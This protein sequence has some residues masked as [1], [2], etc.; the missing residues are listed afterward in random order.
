MNIQ[1]VYIDIDGVLGDYQGAVLAAF[2]DRYGRP[3]PGQGLSDYLKVGG[4]LIGTRIK[5][6]GAAF[7]AQMQLMPDAI[8]I[9]NV[10]LDRFPGDQLYLVS[11]YTD[12]LSCYI[13]K[14]SWVKLLFPAM[15]PRLRLVL[16]KAE[17]AGPGVLLI[18]D[19]DDVAERFQA[20]GGAAIVV[21]RPWNKDHG[22]A[23]PRMAGWLAK[24]LDGLGR[25][26]PATQTK[27][28][29]VGD[30]EAK[31]SDPAKK[32]ETIAEEF[33][34][35]VEVETEEILASL[36]KRPN[37]RLASEMEVLGGLSTLVQ[38]YTECLDHEDCDS[39]GVLAKVAAF[40]AVAATQIHWR[41][42]WDSEG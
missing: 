30:T 6:K 32:A 8:D 22:I 12:D 37:H 2:G 17:L 36:A 21:P 7:W 4:D 20:H 10:I 28:P 29:E 5:E 19:A 23:S 9:L 34:Q 33:C 13:G 18:D 14:A 1:K 24:M 41:R 35:S 42:E 39:F 27:K 11:C 31:K 16:D 40:A 3:H 38:R 26:E 25:L 15:F